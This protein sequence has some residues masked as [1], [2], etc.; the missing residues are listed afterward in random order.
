VIW[1]GYLLIGQQL[2]S[3]LY[4]SQNSWRADRFMAGRAS[5]PVE[6]YY[7]RADAVLVHGTFALVL[8]YVTLR[9]FRRNAGGLF[10]FVF[11]CFVSS[12]LFF[13]LFEIFPS[14]IPLTHLDKILGYYAYKA[15][16]IAD[17]E[18]VFREK[19]FN[20]RVIDDFMGTPVIGSKFSRIAF[21][22]LWTRMA[23]ETSGPPIVPTSS[24]WAIPTSNTV[25]RK[26]TLRSEGWK[27]KFRT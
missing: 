10:L 23:S 9:L 20:R 3:A 16:Y 11:S 2:I 26:R 27:Q 24:C 8:A 22:G 18:L 6:A 15:N 12:F 17:L 1:I 4:N 25:P 7:R 5:T 14:M 13:C 19:P 21:N